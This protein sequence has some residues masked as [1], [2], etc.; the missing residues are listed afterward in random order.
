[1]NG[2][3]VDSITRSSLLE[4]INGFLDCGK[5]HVIQFLAADPSVIAMRDPEYRDVLNRGD[6]NVADGF[7]VAVG[8]RWQGVAT[9]RVPG[10]DAMRLITEWSRER[11]LRH[12]FYGGTEELGRRLRTRLE[13]VSP[14][15]AMAG[16]EAPPFRALNDQDYETAVERIQTAKTDL[17]WI[18]L[19]TPKQHVAAERF[20][21]LN[22]AP[23]ILCVGA[24]FD[25]VAGVKRRAPTWMQRTGLEWLHRLASEPRR[26][27]RRYLVG[28]PRFVWGLVTERI[29][30]GSKAHRT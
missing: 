5:S 11:Q 18:G 20:R 15:I 26:L 24:A 3:R 7:P 22:A 8:L 4:R 23:V 1:M 21:I 25:F 30:R 16:F 19:G 10:S 9:E 27:W 17:L 12:F 29:R 6:L 2:V 13:R 14:G 28:N